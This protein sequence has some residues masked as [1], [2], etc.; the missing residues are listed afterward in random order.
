MGDYTG[1]QSQYISFDAVKFTEQTSIE[2][3]NRSSCSGSF[4]IS[5]NPVRSGSLLIF[6]LPDGFN[7]TVKIFDLSGRLAARAETSV[8]PCIL[9]A[10]IYH[11]VIEE[12]NGHDSIR[13]TVIE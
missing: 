7:G 11:A 3:Q 12:E 4:G 13:F 5:Q 9:P 8:I 6:K 2:E 1:T 10:G